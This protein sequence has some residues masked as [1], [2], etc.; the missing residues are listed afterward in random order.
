MPDTDKRSGERHE[1]VLTSRNNHPLYWTL[2]IVAFIVLCGAVFV[3]TRVHDHSIQQATI[4]GT[5]TGTAYDPTTG[6]TTQAGAVP[7]GYGVDSTPT[8]TNQ[9]ATASTGATSS[10]TTTAT[11]APANQ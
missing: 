7:G 11:P 6:R 5:G 2:T 4:A 3:A 10:S 1:E 8:V 9:P